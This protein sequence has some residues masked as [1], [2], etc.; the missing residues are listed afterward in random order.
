MVK[1]NP[2]LIAWHYIKV[3]K[4]SFKRHDQKFLF[5]IYFIL[6][7][8]VS[9]LRHIN[10]LLLCNKYLVFILIDIILFL[11]IF[12]L[13]SL[14]LFVSI[15]LRESS[16]FLSSNYSIDP[17]LYVSLCLKIQI[18]INK[19]KKK[20]WTRKQTWQEY[21]CTNSAIITIAVVTTI[22]IAI[23]RTIVLSL[24]LFLS[25]RITSS[26]SKPSDA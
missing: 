3:N 2:I 7:S 22:T 16:F 11:E 13:F 18:K 12:S 1:I 21:I 17:Y 25:P 24:S 4:T 26:T 10:P 6:F 20:T 19:K 23:G 9:C 14:S 8:I 15:V 5:S